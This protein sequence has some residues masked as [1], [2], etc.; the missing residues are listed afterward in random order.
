MME[1]ER[2]NTAMSNKGLRGAMG[3]PGGVDLPEWVI[4]II[5]FRNDKISKDHLIY[6]D[7]ERV[8]RI[9][10]KIDKAISEMIDLYT[11][12]YNS[13]GMT[14]PTGGCHNGCPSGVRKNNKKNIQI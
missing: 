6:N 10:N 4:A 11:P 7:P 2:K 5:D 12:Y 3:L 13:N 1:K 9:Y 8:D 14:G